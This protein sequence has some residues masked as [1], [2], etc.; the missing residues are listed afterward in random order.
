MGQRRLRRDRHHAADRRRDCWP[1]RSTSAP[2]SACSTSR[3]ATATPRWPPR[4][5]SPTSPRPTTCRRCS[6][7]AA[8]A[9]RPRGST[10]SFQVAD[11]EQLPFADGSFDVVLSTFGVMF[12]PDHSRAAGRAAARGAQPGGRIGLANWTPEGFIGQLFKVIGGTR[13]A[14]RR[15][16]VTRAVGHRA[17][18]RGAVR[19]RGGLDI[20]CERR[21]FNFRYD[22]PST[23]IQI[24]RDFYGPT[25]KAFARAGR[26]SAE[27]ARPRTSPRCSS[28]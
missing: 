8:A 27:G 22:R 4:A 19:P 28:D 11:A 3:P 15:R 7:K 21:I 2:A 23:C 26:A 1:K 6:S 18:P 9:P 13:A 25:H 5:A 24:F 10:V 12:A 17:A 20:R 16:A 14:A